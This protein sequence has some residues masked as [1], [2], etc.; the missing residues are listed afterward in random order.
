MTRTISLIT[1]I[2]G[3]ALVLAAPAFGQ[4]QDFWN[5]DEQGQKVTNT[6]PGMSAQDLGTLYS[7][8]GS[9][10]QA[11]LLMPDVVDRAVAARMTE[12][13]SL[14]FDNHRS[15]STQGSRLD[16]VVI[17]DVV[18][19]A[20]AARNAGGRGLAFDNH[21]VDAPVGSSGRELVFDNHKVEPIGSPVTIEATGNELDWPQLG[22]AFGIGIAL[23]LGLFA[24]LRLRESRPL[25]H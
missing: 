22:I 4:Q 10:L 12:G 25:A 2:A 6:S 14:V 3:L 20:V 17:P 9:D 23:M 16:A 7:G 11:S 5:Y 19:R 13:R 24:A 1:A 8:G 18:D 21:K 15:E